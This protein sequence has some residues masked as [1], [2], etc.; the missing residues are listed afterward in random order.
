[1]LTLAGICVALMAA[2]VGYLFSSAPASPRQS[3]VLTQ[4]ARTREAVNPSAST[5]GRLNTS[6]APAGASAGVTTPVHALAQAGTQ[7]SVAGQPAAGFAIQMATFQSAARAAQAVQ[8]FRDAGYKA[9]GVERTL[10]DGTAAHAVFLGPYPEHTAAE[11]DR[12]RA[13][14]IPGYGTGLI[15]PINPVVTLP[16]AQ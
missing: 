7:T 13:R 16:K 6:T 15:V 2:L 8:E 9:Y 11:G 4:A 5:E 1:M 3:D 14:Q 10:R 12:E